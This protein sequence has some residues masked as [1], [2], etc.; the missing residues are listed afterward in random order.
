MTPAEKLLE[1]LEQVRCPASVR[2]MQTSEAANI[3]RAREIC[4]AYANPSPLALELAQRARIKAEA[5][6]DDEARARVAAGLPA[7]GPI[8]S[9]KL[10]AAA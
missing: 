4:A 10:E 8:E 9:E 3:A 2:I 1:E 7:W 6:M 5:L